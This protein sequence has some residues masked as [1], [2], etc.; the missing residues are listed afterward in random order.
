ML[1]SPLLALL[2]P[3]DCIG[4][5]AEGSLVCRRCERS[6]EPAEQRCYRCHMLTAQSQ[7]CLE[8][9]SVSPLRAVYA[10]TRY[11]G[12]AKDLVWKLKFGRAKA[13]ADDIGRM[14]A[15]RMSTRST[16]DMII[17]YV[18]TAN[19]RVRQ[20]GYDQAA[21]IAAVVARRLSV[22]CYPLL[23]RAHDRK[24][25]GADRTTR[26]TQL[27]AAFRPIKRRHLYGARVLLIDDVVTTGA[28][29][30]AAAAA[31]IAGGAKSVDAAVFA[32][33]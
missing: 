32:Q 5:S 30:E 4:C 9:R 19:S 22:P 12:I 16:R 18:P 27:Q 31:L 8:C 1:L 2:A 23:S 20:R 13:A 26:T 3:H 24:Q 21:L 6:L 17:T 15:F 25:V 7:T 33:A 29:L 14:V 11:T 10:T 28:T